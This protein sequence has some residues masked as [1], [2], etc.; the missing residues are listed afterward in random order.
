MDIKSKHIKI[1][2]YVWFLKPIFNGQKYTYVPFCHFKIFHWYKKNHLDW[3]YNI[4]NVYN[5]IID[6]NYAL[7]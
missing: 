7:E 2:K 1:F 3:M 4:Y 5:R 6:V